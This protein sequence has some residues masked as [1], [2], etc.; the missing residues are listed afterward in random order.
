MWMAGGRSLKRRGNRQQSLRHRHWIPSD[1]RS[2]QRELKYDIGL[3]STS[4][5][6][7]PL[8][9][10]SRSCGAYGMLATTLATL[11]GVRS[12]MPT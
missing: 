2:W 12:R 11:P 3:R 9:S 7:S 1:L 8:T 5:G 4:S 10:E 6:K